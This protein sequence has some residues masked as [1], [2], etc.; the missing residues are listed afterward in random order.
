MK[1]G[2]SQHISDGQKG[3]PKFPVHSGC[4]ESHPTFWIPIF[5]LL[6]ALTLLI[7]GITIIKIII[8]HFFTVTH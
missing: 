8:L 3:H 7:R 2:G 1:L 5:G 4:V 6:E